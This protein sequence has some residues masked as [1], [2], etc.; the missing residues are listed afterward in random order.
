M[1]IKK[2][3]NSKWSGDIKTGK[4]SI[5]T[6]SGALNN[7]PYGFNT[8]FEDKP[9]SNP[10]ELVAAAHSACFSMAL[11]LALGEAG[12]TADNI[13]TKAVVS[14]DEVDDG[15]AVTHIALEVNAKIADIANEQ[16]QAL[17]DQT[18]KGCPISKLM[19]AEIS[20]KAELN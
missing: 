3:A 4:G 7:Q 11:S 19:N 1:T 8:R 9:G 10:E 15:F 14:L 16:F 2:S 20:L 18:K 13:D 6:Q 17:C 12:F 5:S